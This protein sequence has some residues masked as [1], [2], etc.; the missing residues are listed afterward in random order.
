[1]NA[2]EKIWLYVAL[3]AGAFALVLISRRPTENLPG[4]IAGPLAESE[5]AWKAS[6]EAQDALQTYEN[7]TGQRLQ[8]L[9]RMMAEMQQQRQTWEQ[10]LSQYLQTYEAQLERTPPYAI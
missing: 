9:E 1:M 3:L 7:E 5:Q 10:P 8:D 2:S 4:S 6:Q